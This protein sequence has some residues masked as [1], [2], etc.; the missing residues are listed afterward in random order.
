LA[1]RKSLSRVAVALPVAAAT[2]PSRRYPHLGNPLATALPK[3]TD[4]S[5]VII[6]YIDRSN[7]TPPYVQ[8]HKHWFFCFHCTSTTPPPTK[9]SRSK[10]K[11]AG[12]YPLDLDMHALWPGFTIRRKSGRRFGIF[13]IMSCTTTT[14]PFCTFVF[15]LTL[16]F[17]TPS[18]LG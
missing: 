6:T 8:L 14:L 3:H 2:V 12:V 10:D 9:T 7:S 5:I 17:Y 18:S 4:I 15:P 16:R 13:H 11:G 1:F